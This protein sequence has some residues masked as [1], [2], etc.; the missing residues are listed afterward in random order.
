[1]IL[2]ASAPYRLEGRS[3]KG[4]VRESGLACRQGDVVGG[5]GLRQRC[6]GGA[7]K[8]FFLRVFIA[9]PKGL[10]GGVQASKGHGVGY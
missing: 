2:D 3:G 5:Y 4:Y 6:A 10:N 8:V 7:R 9:W 1:M